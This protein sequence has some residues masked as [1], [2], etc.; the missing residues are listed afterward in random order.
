M[1]TG[2]LLSLAGVATAASFHVDLAGSNVTGDGSQAHPWLSIPFAVTSVPNGTAGNP[3]VIHPGP[4]EFAETSDGSQ[5]QLLI[6]NRQFVQI[7]G[8]GPFIEPGL[9]GSARRSRLVI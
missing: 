8:A 2:W 6:A 4:G 7:K 3:T 5:G 9:N 1:A